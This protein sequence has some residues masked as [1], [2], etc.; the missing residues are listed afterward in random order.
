MFKNVAVKQINE[1][2]KLI[3]ETIPNNPKTRI[4]APS[5]TPILPNEIG[6]KNIIFNNGLANKFSTNF[7]FAL[8]PLKTMFDTTTLVN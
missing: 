1:T 4:Y 2:N 6:N 3:S 5:R 7:K 8:N